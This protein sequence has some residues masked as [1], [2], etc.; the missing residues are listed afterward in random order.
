MSEAEVLGVIIRGH[1]PTTGILNGRI[2]SL[3]LVIAQFRSKDLRAA[4][5]TAIS[6]D[7]MAV[8][9]DMLSVINSKHAVWN[10]DLCVTVLPK[11]LDLL[12]SKYETYITVGCDTL[13]LVLK[14]F[15]SV[16]KNNIQSPVGS[17][18]VD[19]TREERSFI[20]K[21]QSLPSIGSSF[22]EVHE[23]MCNFLD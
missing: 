14:H 19:I 13:K 9:V 11:M 17:F 22:R 5:D 20:V 1:E 7:D 6:I 4:V 10:L 21:K 12:Q 3:K 15:G 16:I 23:L 18:G 2:R 8:L